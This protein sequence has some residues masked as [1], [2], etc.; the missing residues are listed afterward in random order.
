MLDTAPA[1]LR[2]VY[3]LNPVAVVIDNFRR[4]VLHGETPDVALVVVAGAISIFLLGLAY[5]SFKNLEA[6]MADYI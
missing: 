6:T 2:R 1:G 3:L 4:V 5:V